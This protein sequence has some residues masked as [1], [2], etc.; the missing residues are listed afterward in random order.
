MDSNP[1]QPLLL[2]LPSD[3]Q[4]IVWEYAKPWPRFYQV[5]IEVKIHDWKL[6]A[7]F[8]DISWPHYRGFVCAQINA[9]L[10]EDLGEPYPER[11]GYH[12][13]MQLTENDTVLLVREF[14]IS[15]DDNKEFPTNTHELDEFLA[16][17]DVEIRDL[18]PDFFELV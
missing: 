18:Y 2:S 11:C 15:L 1:L 4:L 12:F 7:D 5:E 17:T 13:G 10:I 14:R 3:L 8:Y 16:M 9:M 6:A